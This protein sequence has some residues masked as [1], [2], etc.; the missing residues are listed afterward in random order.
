MR[1]S[2]RAAVDRWRITPAKGLRH[3]ALPVRSAVPPR[4]ALE[5]EAAPARDAPRHRNNPLPEHELSVRSVLT[6][7]P[8]AVPFVPTETSEHH[9]CARTTR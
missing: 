8:I 4:E 3:N 2:A 1:E 7:K 6:E 5:G 9:M